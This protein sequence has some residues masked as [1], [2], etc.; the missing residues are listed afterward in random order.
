MRTFHWAYPKLMRGE[1]DEGFGWLNKSL[2]TPGMDWFRG[3]RSDPALGV[4]A[5]LMYYLQP[6]VR[7][8]SAPSICS[9]PR[10]SPVSVA[11]TIPQTIPVS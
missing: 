4:T 11:S 7:I 8:E 1:L 6:P 9:P 2:S 3:Y 10:V 5:W